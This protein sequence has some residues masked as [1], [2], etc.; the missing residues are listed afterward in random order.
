MDCRPRLCSLCKMTHC[1]GNILTQTDQRLLIDMLATSVSCGDPELYQLMQDNAATILIMYRGCY[2]EVDYLRAQLGLLD[3]ALMYTRNKVDTIKSRSHAEGLDTYR[4]KYENETKAQ[5]TSE[6]RAC[7]FGDATSFQTFQRDS[8]NRM[9]S[10]SDMESNAEGN[11]Q[12]TRWDRSKQTAS[13]YSTIFDYANSASY[14]VGRGYN[15][16][17]SSNSGKSYSK[18]SLDW[19]PNRNDLSTGFFLPDIPDPQAIWDS[20]KGGMI[21]DVMGSLVEG[22]EMEY[23][24]GGVNMPTRD[25]TSFNDQIDDTFVMQ[26]TQ[27]NVPYE[28]FLDCCC[29]LDGND[30]YDCP[31]DPNDPPGVPVC[32]YDTY[33]PYPSYG[34]GYNVRYAISIGIPSVGPLRVDWAVGQQFRQSHVVTQGCT[35]AVGAGYTSNKYEQI[36]GSKS[37]GGTDVH[38]ESQTTRDIHTVGDSFR[39]SR[40]DT[41]AGSATTGDAFSE[42]HTGSDRQAHAERRAANQ[43]TSWSKSK[44]RGSG[45]SRSD[46]KSTY[47]MRKWSQIF[48][49]LIDMY[50]RIF[51]QIKTFERARALSIGSSVGQIQSCEYSLPADPIRKA[52]LSKCLTSRI[53]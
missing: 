34:R 18:T 45:D 28:P 37:I 35:R 38:D 44:G 33:D 48:K 30:L 13:G 43:G 46:S 41:T 51:E 6:Q 31:P 11:T 7:S 16:S 17:T 39:D 12:T 32:N 2:A 20:I 19:G 52:R 27:D 9:R 36:D 53:H 50:N 21:W 23:D 22:G 8:V 42:S 26:G 1:Q 5:R 14:G 10:E 24:T 29:D 47:E 40:S 3:L 4:A 49:S 15:V 25:N